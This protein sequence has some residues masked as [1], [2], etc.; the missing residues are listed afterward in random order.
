[1]YITKYASQQSV[2]FR[3]QGTRTRTTKGN[4]A[5]G[6]NARAARHPKTGTTV[7]V[8][9]TLHGTTRPARYIDKS[10]GPY[11]WQGLDCVVSDVA[12]Y[13]V[14]ACQVLVE[15]FLVGREVVRLVKEDVDAS[16]SLFAAKSISCCCHS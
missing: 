16:A 9:P 7:V 2:K 1:M 3:A 14:G 6:G 15:V 5:G 12:Q 11:H 4:A 13:M 8:V 10:L